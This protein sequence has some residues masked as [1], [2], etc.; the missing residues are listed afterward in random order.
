MKMKKET[1]ETLQKVGKITGIAGAILGF[2]DAGLTVVDKV[3]T[4]KE[5]EIEDK[6]KKGA[7]KK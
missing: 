2:I 1:L 3:A 6:K 5:E 4:E 7:K